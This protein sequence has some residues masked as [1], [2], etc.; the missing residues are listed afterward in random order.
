MHKRDP[1]PFTPIA[2]QIAETFFAEHATSMHIE[3]YN[4]FVNN[5]F[6]KILDSI[7]PIE[8]NLISISFSSPRFSMCQT[9]VPTALLT[10]QSC[11]SNVT[12]LA[13]ITKKASSKN[14]KKIGKDKIT[15][16]RIAFN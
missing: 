1:I 15:K 5:T 14:G 10:L 11:M 2:K 4:Y 9:S 12:I 13:T 6:G 8:T 7:V 3:S 16:H